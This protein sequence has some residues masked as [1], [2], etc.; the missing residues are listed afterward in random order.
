ML[1]GHV[2]I[3]DADPGTPPLGGYEWMQPGT[4]DTYIRN[5]NN[6]AWVLKGN[7]DQA[8]LGNLT[9]EGGAVSGLISGAHGLAPAESPD[10]QKSAKKDGG[11]LAL[12][13]DLNAM[14]DELRGEFSAVA[15]EIISSLLTTS[16]TKA[17]IAMKMGKSTV[18][19]NTTYFTIPQPEFPGGVQASYSQCAWIVSLQAVSWSDVTGGSGDTTPL[20]L[21]QHP[22]YP[23]QYKAWSFNLNDAAVG[24]YFHYLIIGV[25]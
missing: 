3:Q 6:T 14:A 24:G 13:D 10:F 12:V 2:Y 22:T 17:N 15:A 23:Y 16:P 4:G 7:V 20:Y 9:L 1:V 5:G 18:T 19:T 21:E 25:R 11:N 8:N